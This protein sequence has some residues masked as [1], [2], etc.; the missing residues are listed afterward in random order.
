MAFK[1]EILIFEQQLTMDINNFEFIYHPIIDEFHPWW[2]IYLIQII[3]EI[4]NHAKMTFI[5]MKS[6]IYGHI[7]PCRW[8][9]IT[10][11]FKFQAKSSELS[12][13][14]HAQAILVMWAIPTKVGRPFDFGPNSY[15]GLDVAYK[16]ILIWGQNLKDP[17]LTPLEQIICFMVLALNF[18]LAK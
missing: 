10:L 15:L 16:H 12:L 8:I 2:F 7:H 17:P 6:F 18:D 5:H 1:F 11:N 3:N 13:H 4:Q 9:K 14:T